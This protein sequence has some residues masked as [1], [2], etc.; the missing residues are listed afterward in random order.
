MM[1]NVF[2]VIFYENKTFFFF[3]NTVK[4]LLSEFQLSSLKLTL[5]NHFKPVI[6]AFLLSNLSII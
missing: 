2:E 4:A 3:Y 5:Q 6:L 1:V